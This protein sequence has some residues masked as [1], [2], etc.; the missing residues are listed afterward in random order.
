MDPVPRPDFVSYL[1]IRKEE[2]KQ[3][4]ENDRNI[5]ELRDGTV[6]RQLFENYRL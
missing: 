4:L 2:I 6:T 1:K 5:Y 3:A